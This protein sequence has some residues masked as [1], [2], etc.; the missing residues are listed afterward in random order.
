ML[1]KTLLVVVGAVAV[2]MGFAGSAEAATFNI[3][4]DDT[5]GGGIDGNIVF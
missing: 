5:L 4:Y 1:N 2:G 3:V